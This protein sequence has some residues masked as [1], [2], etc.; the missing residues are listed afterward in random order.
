MREYR[1]GYRPN[2]RNINTAHGSY[3]VLGASVFYDVKRY[4]IGLKLDNLTNKEY[5][6][7]GIAGRPALYGMVAQSNCY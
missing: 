1:P 3:T 2:R 4:R 6:T 5:Y 7:G